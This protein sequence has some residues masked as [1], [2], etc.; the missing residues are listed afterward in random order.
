MA[1]LRSI[2]L[3]SSVR[4]HF[5]FLFSESINKLKPLMK[6]TQIRLATCALTAGVLCAPSAF[7]FA[8]L[9]RGTL[10]AT[11]NLSGAYDTNIYSNSTEVAD[12]TASFNPGLSYLRKAG[13]IES[14]IKTGVKAFSFTDAKGQDSIDPYVNGTFTLDRAEKGQASV[15]LDYARTTGANE[16]LLARVESDEYR[17]SGRVNYFY[18]E[19]TGVRLNTNYRLS[20]F[21]TPGYNDV[22]S[23]GLGGGLV[24]RYSPKLVASATYDFSPEK[25][26]NRALVSNPSSQNHRFQF[27]LEGELAP[28]LTGSTSLGYAYRAF[29]NGG[30]DDTMLLGVNLD[31]N[32][33]QKSTFSLSASNDFNT[34]AGAESVRAFDVRLSFRQGLSEALT[35]SAFVGYENSDITQQPS[36]FDR[37]DEAYNVGL[38]L[39]Y[40]INKQWSAGTGLTHRMNQSNLGTAEYQRTI[41]SLSLDLSF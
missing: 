21:N 12:Y 37:A 41:L 1:P 7:G 4:W 39:S 16:L 34:T 28:K 32:P 27:G 14:S 40:G 2:V 6:H 18:S 22:S 33:I 17:G 9:A 10:T 31:W 36:T 38:S 25:A 19:K 11:A 30:A 23:Y 20:Q 13:S 8:E 3:Q 26:T 24:H 35:A 15:S 5:S 29:D